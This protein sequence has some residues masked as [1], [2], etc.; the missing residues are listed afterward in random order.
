[1][2]E[3]RLLS[4][5]QPVSVSYTHLDVYKRQE[6]H[7]TDKQ[8]Y[9]KILNIIFENGGKYKILYAHGQQGIQETP[10]YP[11]NRP[12]VFCFEIP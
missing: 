2:W 12:F 9:R 11:K 5:R 3:R 10:E 8:I 7:N 1:M 6:Q 4:L